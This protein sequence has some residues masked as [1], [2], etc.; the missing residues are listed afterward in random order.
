MTNYPFAS[1]DQLDDV[2]S[3]RW[4]EKALGRGVDPAPAPAAVNARGRDHPRTPMQWDASEHA[5]SPRARAWR[6]GQPQPRR[7]ERGRAGGRPRQRLRALPPAIGLRRELPAVVDGDFTLVLADHPTRSVRLRAAS[8]TTSCCWSWRT[9][10][11]H[12][13]GVDVPDGWESSE[14]LLASGPVPTRYAGR[15]PWP[16]EARVHRRTRTC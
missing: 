8:A 1:L 14:V 12:D 16:V 11:S 15:P 7:D 5:G 3:R 2:E 10:R 6:A 9:S 4:A 13:V